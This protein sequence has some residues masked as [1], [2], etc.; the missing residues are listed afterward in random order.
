M[1][2]CSGCNDTGGA[3]YNCRYVNPPTR[4]FSRMPKERR[5]RSLAV[6]P[7]TPPDW[8]CSWTLRILSG[9]SEKGCNSMAQGSRKFPD[10]SVGGG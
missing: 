4:G 9:V 8:Q 5:S 3:S 2:G 1:M 10:N 6:S 7:P